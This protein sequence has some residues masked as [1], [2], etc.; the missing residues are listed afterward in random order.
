M[1]HLN[2]LL[3]N[4]RLQ[5]EIKNIWLVMCFYSDSFFTVVHLF[6]LLTFYSMLSCHSNCLVLRC[7]YQFQHTH[8]ALLTEWIEQNWMSDSAV[9]S[10]TY[11]CCKLKVLSKVHNFRL[12]WGR[13]CYIIIS[14]FHYIHSVRAE[15]I[16]RKLLSRSFVL[17]RSDVNLYG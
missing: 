1:N 14:N 15:P 6:S 11:L 7:R 13:K 8:A 10:R 2:L 9:V 3:D 16:L 12:I 17:Y 5:A 4:Y